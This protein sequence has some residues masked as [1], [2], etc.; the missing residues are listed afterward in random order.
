MPGDPKECRQ[1]ALNCTLMTVQQ[2]RTEGRNGKV[3]VHLYSII[4]A[5]SA[6]IRDGSELRASGRHR[7]QFQDRQRS[8]GG[9]RIIYLT[10]SAIA[11]AAATI[12]SRFSFVPLSG[13]AP[14]AGVI[15]QGRS[16]Y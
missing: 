1:H 4:G 5:T 12:K 11:G 6:D 2:I 15:G 13:S 10:P 16:S 3:A 14:N 9:Q 8:A 7:S